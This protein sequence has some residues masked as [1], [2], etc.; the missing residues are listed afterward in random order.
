MNGYDEDGFE[1]WAEKRLERMPSHR[2]IIMMEDELGI[3]NI[4]SIKLIDDEKAWAYYHELKEMIE[5][6]KRKTA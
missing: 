1:E 2:E 5:A 4:A 6:K 3:P